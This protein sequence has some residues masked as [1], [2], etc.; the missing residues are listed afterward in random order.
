[1][2]QV[3]TDDISL[4]MQ[5]ELLHDFVGAI[6]RLLQWKTA[7]HLRRFAERRHECATQGLFDGQGFKKLGYLKGA[8]NAFTHNLAARLTRDVLA[9]QNDATRIWNQGAGDEI[10]KS[11]LTRAVWSNHR[12]Q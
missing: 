5:T 1:M 12:A 10:K 6:S 11:R 8:T 4:G 2:G 7:V 3:A 9:I